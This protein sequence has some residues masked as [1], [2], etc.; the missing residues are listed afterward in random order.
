MDFSDWADRVSA[1]ERENARLRGLLDD[2]QRGRAEPP[3]KPEMYDLAIVS[4]APGLVSPSEPI[5]SQTPSK[6]VEKPL[7]GQRS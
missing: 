4:G 6:P 7:S 2:I 1:L 5:L 3:N